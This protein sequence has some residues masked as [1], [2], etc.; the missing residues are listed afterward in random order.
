MF[1]EIFR[2]SETHVPLPKANM[3]FSLWK[4]KFLESKTSWTKWDLPSWSSFLSGFPSRAATVAGA[5]Q[6]GILS[7]GRPG[8]LGRLP[9]SKSSPNKAISVG[10]MASCVWIFDMILLIDSLLLYTC[11]QASRR[12]H[13]AFHVWTCTAVQGDMP[14]STWTLYPFPHGRPWKIMEHKHGFLVPSILISWFIWHWV[15]WKLLANCY[16]VP[17]NYGKII[18][19]NN[20][21]LYRPVIKH[22]WLENPSFTVVP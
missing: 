8:G 9:G 18:G 16:S 17:R 22:G 13:C 5:R 6:V 12:T 4:P 19:F 20:I 2:N 21:P 15:T 10:K 14:N 11:H 1:F 7:Q 3:F